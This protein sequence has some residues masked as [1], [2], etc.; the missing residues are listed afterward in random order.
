MKAEDDLGVVD[1]ACAV[2]NNDELRIIPCQ[3]YTPSPTASSLV[4]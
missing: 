4:S 2:G 3:F 1:V